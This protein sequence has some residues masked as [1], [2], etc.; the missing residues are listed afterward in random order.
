MPVRLI[1]LGGHFASGKTTL[2]LRFLALLK[3]GEG[4]VGALVN[5]VGPVDFKLVAAMADCPV[6]EI[7]RLCMCIKEKD[8]KAALKRLLDLNDEIILVEE[9]GFGNPHKCWNTL[10]NHMSVLNGPFELNP[11][12]VLVDG[13]FLTKSYQG[14]VSTLPP[15]MEQQLSEADII[16][17]NKTDLIP[18]DS[19]ETIEGIL[20]GVNARARIF[21]I[22][23]ASG[24]GVDGLLSELMTTRWTP[25]PPQTVPEVTQRRT[26]EFSNMHWSA[27]KV[28]FELPDESAFQDTMRKILTL[29]GDEMLKSGGQIVRVKAYLEA[30]SNRIYASLTPDL[31]VEF[32]P[33]SEALK[34]RSGVLTLSFV[35]KGIK[36]E[37]VSSALKKAL[38]E[39]G[40]KFTVKRV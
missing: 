32:Y 3:K 9:I 37:E 17:V 19:K 7:S 25:R 39:T 20:R 34:I 6:E 28:E 26:E 12:T 24:E 38:S 14:F 1:V 5:D 22:S 33:N 35:V 13:E 23:A 4:R 11:I 36:G 27:Y 18:V 8:L 29:S 16:V 10:S 40:G 2:L 21:F 31:N 15:L 30:P